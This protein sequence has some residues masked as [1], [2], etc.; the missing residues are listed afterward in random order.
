M[1]LRKLG[2]LNGSAEIR[3]VYLS[4]CLL[5]GEMEVL[6]ECSSQSSIFGG[7]SEAGVLDGSHDYTQE[8]G[9]PALSGD[10]SVNRQRSLSATPLQRPSHQSLSRTKPHPVLPGNGYPHDLSQR[11]SVSRKDNSRV[12]SL[13]LSCRPQIKKRRSREWTRSIHHILDGGS[14]LSNICSSING[15]KSNNHGPFESP[16]MMSSGS[17][18]V[19]TGACGSPG[20]SMSSEERLLQSASSSLQSFVDDGLNG[21]YFSSSLR[22]ISSSDELFSGQSELLCSDGSVSSDVIGSPDFCGL[23]E[24]MDFMFD[25]I[26]MDAS[27]KES[28]EIQFPASPAAPSRCHGSLQPS[29]VPASFGSPKDIDQKMKNTLVGRDEHHK[30]VGAISQGSHDSSNS[31]CVAGVMQVTGLWKGQNSGSNGLGEVLPSPRSLAHLSVTVS[32]AFS[33]SVCPPKFSGGADGLFSGE[34]NWLHSPSQQDP[35]CAEPGEQSVDNSPDA[36]R[37]EKDAFDYSIEK[38]ALGCVNLGPEDYQMHKAAKVCNSTTL[39]TPGLVRI[40]EN[41]VNQLCQIQ[42]FGSKGGMFKAPVMV[43][44]QV[45]SRSESDF[46]G[47]RIVHLLIAGAEAVATRDMDLASVILVRLKELVS[48]SGSTIQRVAACFSDGLQSWIQGGRS[49]DHVAKHESNMDILSAFQIL[50][51]ISPYIKFGHLTAN[52]AILEAVEEEKRIHIV[53]FEIMEGIQWPSFMQALATRRGGPPEIRITALFRPYAKRGLATVQETGRRLSEFANSLNLT[54]TYNLLRVE[55]EEEFRVSSLKLIKG[56]A[57]VVNCMLHLPHMPYKTATS[58]SSFL[59]GMRKLSPVILT[60]V[61][62]ELGCNSPAL[63]SYFSEALHHYS[64]MFDSLEACLSSEPVGRMLV[65]RVFLAPRITNA[66]TFRGGASPRS[67]LRT[68]FFRRNWCSLVSTAGF[69][70]LPLSFR[71]LSQA[72]LLLGLFKDGFKVDENGDRLCLGWHSKALIA[73]SAWN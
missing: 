6:M 8:C 29:S 57:L 64:A 17:M 30:T 1:D 21:P 69:K 15:L 54:F 25:N 73:A 13:P 36:L 41:V 51:E 55:N 27:C 33:T 52:Q 11:F 23:N 49:P 7:K 60:L 61:E 43:S 72:R 20:A 39:Q 19:V 46:D 28:F 14:C 68:D 16:I 47:V 4:K 50:H 56:E 32:E 63:S 34:K 62:E 67:E 71:N 5:C 65:E 45:N 44:P 24:L 3:D 35:N 42:G 12:C 48:C 40:K 66:V 22:S 38:S 59:Q 70:S 2:G 26:N 53:D 18:D 31:Q 58:V 37:E 9:H 10:P